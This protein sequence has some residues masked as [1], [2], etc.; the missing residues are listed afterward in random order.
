MLNAG[1]EAAEIAVALKR[2]R[3]AIYARLQRR[4]RKAKPPDE[5]RSGWRRSNRRFHGWHGEPW[6]Q[7]ESTPGRNG[8]ERPDSEK[9]YVMGATPKHIAL[10]LQATI[11]EI[12]NRPR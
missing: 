1:K 4:Y 11:D 7:P 5:P 12:V 3:Q 10:L 9:F 8:P 2:T 6:G